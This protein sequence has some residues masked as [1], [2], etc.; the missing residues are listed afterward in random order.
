MKLLYLSRAYTTHDRRFFD[1]FIHS[2]G[3]G[4]ALR[5]TSERLDRRAMPADVADLGVLAV[6]SMSAAIDQWVGQA[7][8]FRSAVLAVKPDVILAGPI[9]SGAFLAALSGCRPYVAM[10]WGSDILTEPHRS[11]ARGAVT[12]FALEQSAAALGDCDAVRKAIKSFSRLGDRDIVTFPWGIDVGP[13]GQKNGRSEIRGRR[14]WQNNRVLVSTRTW[15]RIY[16]IDVLLAAF[17]EARKTHPDIRLLLLGDGSQHRK[18][19][20]MI[21]RLDLTEVVH[22]PGRVSCDQL[23][24]YFA[25]ADLYVSSTLSDGTSISLLEAMASG[26]PVIVTKGYGN[27]EWVSHGRNGWLAEP[28]SV[29]SMAAAVRTACSA[30][31][32]WKN[33]GMLNRRIVVARGNWRKNVPKLLALL[34]RIASQA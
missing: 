10:S 32:R 12:R 14:G 16:A 28:G 25:A 4:H 31:A 8:R 23:P 30:R 15:E 17:A 27:L 11:A 7:L 3:K 33:I 29:Q 21:R 18:I 24:H 9:Q 20:A 1:A 5:L 34:K 22:T 26:L 6:P 2:G 13:F 19:R